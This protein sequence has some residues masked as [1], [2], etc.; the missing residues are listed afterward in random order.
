MNLSCVL[1][2]AVLAG[3]LIWAGCGL[4]R[5]RSALCQEREE[6]RRLRELVRAGAREAEAELE[7]MR[8]LRHDMRHFLQMAEGGAPLGSLLSVLET[9]QEQPA[10]ARDGSWAV[11]SLV[12]GYQSLAEDEGFSVDFRL[13]HL[14]VSEGQLPDVCLVLSNLLE[15]A[16]EALRR[17]GGGWLRA[18]S[19]FADGYLTI[20]VG[21]SSS[22]RLR[23]V[24][25][26]YL[27]SKAEGRFGVGLA[28]VQEIARKYGGQAEFSA[29]GKEFRAA[30]FLTCASPAAQEDASPPAPPPPVSGV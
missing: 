4:R 29:D 22:E 21:N 13:E 12:R 6:N 19:T 23:R 3:L 16:V 9:A 20:V 11:S 24:N 17:E 25:G 28:T 10:S 30:V 2:V 1:A 8:R 5:L 14:P 27:S 7:Q 26:R 15:N 18:R